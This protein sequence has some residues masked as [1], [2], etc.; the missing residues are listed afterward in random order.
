[1]RNHGYGEDFLSL[2]L[3]PMS[4]A[5][6]STPPEMM[7]AF[8]AA[9]LIRF[10]HNHGFL[11]LKT[12]HPWFTV[13]GG[14]RTYVEK[15]SAPWKDRIR[16]GDGVARVS[17]PGRQVEVT[18]RSGRKESFDK[19]IL[20]CHAD[21]ALSMLADPRPD[22]SRLLREF[23]YQANTATVHTDATVMP[24][25][26][27]AWS[28]WNYEINRGSRGE[29][30]TATHYWMNSLQGV[31]NIEDYFVSINRPWAIEPR[32][33][34]RTIAYEHPLFTLGAMRAQKELPRLNMSAKGASETYYCG[35]YFRYGFH[36]DAL[37]SAAKLSEELLGR[38]PWPA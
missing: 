36:E 13:E 27:L 14:S 25:T 21:H 33:V 10:F 12:Q 29:S 24:R 11:G 2:Y 18:L 30:S 4:S 22:E 19:V 34:L 6:W 20:A 15:L 9:S 16:L 37:L 31:S 1:V 7:N 28:S 3:A 35:S 23:K 17:R 32:R 38:D 26:R 5:V 8:P